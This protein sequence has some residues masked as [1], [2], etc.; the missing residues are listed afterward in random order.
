MTPPSQTDELTG[1]KAKLVS[2]TIDLMGS[3]G[4]ESTSVQDILD[5]AQ[6]T[7][8]N[9]YYHFKSK[10]DLCLTALEMMENY[11]FTYMLEPTLL[12]EELSPK[13]RFRA[14]FNVQLSKM[15][16]SSCKKGCPFSNLAS[17]T[18][19]FHPEFQQ[20]LAQFYQRQVRLIEKCF[21]EGVEKGE[22]RSNIAPSK[23]ASML[24]STMMGATLLAKAYKDLDVLRQ[25]IELLFQLIAKE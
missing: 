4:F 13:E 17:E 2:V 24:L 10:E 19:D 6:V 9:F 11:F 15:E 14:F 22:F 7:K 18:S 8:S 3:K 21:E 23:V 25:N 12:N 16:T 20:R 1:S 5:A